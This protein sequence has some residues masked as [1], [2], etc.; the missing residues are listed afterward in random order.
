MG[1]WRKRLA[2]LGLCSLI[3][4]TLAACNSQATPAAAA[5]AAPADEQVAIGTPGRLRLVEFYADW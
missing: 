4:T 1:Q 3:L 5:D 2:F